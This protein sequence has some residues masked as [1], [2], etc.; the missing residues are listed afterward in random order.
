MSAFCEQSGWSILLKT[1][2][3]LV[4]TQ[5]PSLLRQIPRHLAH[6]VARLA[7]LDFVLV[8]ALVHVDHEGV[9][10]NSPAR[11]GELGRK[12]GVEEIH[13]LRKMKHQ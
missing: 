3:K 4:E 13:E 11:V 12:G 6:P 7:V 8:V 1:Y 2:L 9:E 5:H 10:V